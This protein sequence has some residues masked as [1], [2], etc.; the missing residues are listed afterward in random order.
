MLSWSRGIHFT[1]P[2]QHL[3]VHYTTLWD[4][5]KWTTIHLARHPRQMLW[6]HQEYCEP[7]THVTSDQP[8]QCRT[9]MGCVRCLPIRVWRILRPRWRLEDN[10]ARRL[11]VQEIHWHTTFVLHIRTWNPWHH[12]STQKVGRWAPCT[13]WNEAYIML[14]SCIDYALDMTCIQSVSQCF[15]V[16]GIL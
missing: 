4:V 10:E 9:R 13:V 7:Q 6:D 12:R 14:V 1:F 2:T 15:I 11:H 5:L 8:Q 3:G 16:G